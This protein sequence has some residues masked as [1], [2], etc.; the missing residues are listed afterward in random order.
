[1][2]RYFEDQIDGLK[3]KRIDFEKSEQV[4]TENSYVS[5]FLKEM[6][7]REETDKFK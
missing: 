7:K 4:F 6:Q 1:M 2:H 3:N 5:G